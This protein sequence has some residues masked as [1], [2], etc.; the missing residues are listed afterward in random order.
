[1]SASVAAQPL[2][3]CEPLRLVT[4]KLKACTLGVSYGCYPG[5]SKFWVKNKCVGAF[6]CDGHRGRYTEWCGSCTFATGCTD[7]IRNCSCTR[8]PA[9]RKN[10][11]LQHPKP[12]RDPSV[13]QAVH[14]TECPDTSTCPPAG[15]QRKVLVMQG[16]KEDAAFGN[17]F[18]S[19]VANFLLYTGHKGYVPLI[20]FEAAW[21]H[22]TMGSSWAK[23][24]RALWE[25]FFEG[26]CPNVSAWLQR[27]PNVVRARPKPKSFYYPGVQYLFK[28]PIRQVCIRMPSDAF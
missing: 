8:A 14:F 10:A 20:Q 22:K 15:E 9:L 5:E 11:A 12:P 28:W 17:L 27:C 4:S 25:S 1:M 2:F 18:F 7:G 13:V 16:A 6:Q 19:M 21:V 26:Y 3:P 23:E 24:G